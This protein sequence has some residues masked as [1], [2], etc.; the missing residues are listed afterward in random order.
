MLGIQG[1]IETMPVDDLLIYLLRRGLEGTVRCA[2]GPRE[3]T[4]AVVG[5]EAIMAS[6]NNPRE[7]LGQFLI[8]FGH[9]SEEQLD[10]AFETQK[11]TNVYLGRI[12]TMIGLVDEASLQTILQLKIRETILS[13]T[14][15]T[16]GTFEFSQGEIPELGPGVQ[17]SVGLQNIKDETAFRKTAWAS[18]RQVFPSG[19]DHLEINREAL[20][21][22]SLHPLDEQIMRLA[23]NEESLDSISLHLHATEFAFYQ[24]LFALNAKGVVHTVQKD[25]KDES[26]D[27]EVVE[28]NQIPVIVGQR[29][30]L[31]AILERVEQLLRKEQFSEAEAMAI[32]AVSLAPTD[33]T[34]QQSLKEAELRLLDQLRERHQS[35][36]LAP[37]LIGDPSSEGHRLSPAER[38]LLKRF[39]GGRT[40]QQVIRVSPIRELDALKLVDQFVQSNLVIMQPPSP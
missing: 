25:Q 38:Y 9:I 28:A 10:Q 19:S 2:Q 21:G 7:Y 30:D 12:L 34:A 35:A 26:I 36:R 29:L 13:L 23:E 5:G 15:W 20:G 14:D 31:A 3:K 27:I 16:H 24:R 18:I 11:E 32:Q 37:S 39:D 4:F 6:S 40:L 8:N 33:A 1:T 22:E 17:A